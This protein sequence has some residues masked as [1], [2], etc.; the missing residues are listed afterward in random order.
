M[1]ENIFGL[2]AF[3]G[4]SQ[5]P[6]STPPKPVF[7]HPVARGTVKNEN[8][9][10]PYQDYNEPATPQPVANRATHPIRK[11]DDSMAYPVAAV[12]GSMKSVTCKE[13]V[14]PNP[15]SSAMHGKGRSNKSEK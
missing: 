14:I 5:R 13:S 1:F 7:Q 15:F 10:R 4:P 12:R 9:N 11:N 3:I 6:T 2:H 8:L